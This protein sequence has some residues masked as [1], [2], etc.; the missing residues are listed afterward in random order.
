MSR[1]YVYTNQ[2]IANN[3]V[4]CT[5]IGVGDMKKAPKALRYG[6]NQPCPFR[7]F[8]TTTRHVLCAVVLRM[9]LRGE[10][11]VGST[12]FNKVGIGLLP[13]LTI[14]KARQGKASKGKSGWAAAGRR[15]ALDLKERERILLLRFDVANRATERGF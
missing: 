9:I 8:Q 3:S 5:V 10:R 1:V 2:A 7:L 11:F 13:Q 15:G 14:C 6:D 4:C 12:A